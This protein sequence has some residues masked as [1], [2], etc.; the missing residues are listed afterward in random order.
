MTQHPAEWSSPPRVVSPA[1]YLILAGASSLVMVLGSV[2]GFYAA[3]P[4]SPAAKIEYRSVPLVPSVAATAPAQPVARP[5][6]TVLTP[7]PPPG[8]AGEPAAAASAE[9]AVAA[10]PPPP[11]E[12]AAAPPPP[13]EPAAAAAPAGSVAA[14]EPAAAPA[15][16]EAH[17]APAG[18]APSGE[19][20]P[21]L[22]KASG[23]AHPVIGHE[24][25]P[26]GSFRWEQEAEAATR[27]AIEAR[28]QSGRATA[29]ELKML[30]AI[31]R[32]QG[33]EA[34]KERAQEALGK[35][36]G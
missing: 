31:C 3:A 14:A 26:D 32:H 4:A 34:C 27:R 1:R 22:A 13:A 33:D 35:L 21:A 9:P 16:A 17:K 19:A 25:L 24:P 12:P 28:L 6:P 20:A 2:G 23:K 10:G 15:S 8:A 7:I 5:R 30:K 18:A 11:A 36:P 29:E